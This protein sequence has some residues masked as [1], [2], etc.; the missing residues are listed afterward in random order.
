MQRIRGEGWQEE[1]LVGFYKAGGLAIMASHTMSPLANGGH[2]MLLGG[3]NYSAGGGRRFPGRRIKCSEREIES[4]ARSS[5][6]NTGIKTGKTFDVYL[7]LLLGT[8]LP[9]FWHL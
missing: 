2:A 8:V 9:L 5:R 6:L 3:V 4:G 7:E 1:V